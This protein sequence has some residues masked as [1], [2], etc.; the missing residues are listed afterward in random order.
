MKYVK[1]AMLRTGAIIIAIAATL[2]SMVYVAINV[3]ILS[4]ISEAV[5]S[6]EEGYE[7]WMSLVITGCVINTLIGGLEQCGYTLTIHKIFLYLNNI[8]VDKVLNADYALYTKYSTATLIT[9]HADLWKMASLLR[10]ISTMITSVINFAFVFIAIVQI[11]FEL[12][13]V[14]LPLYSICGI[15][16]YFIIKKWVE[17]DNRMHEIGHSIYK[18]IGEIIEGYQDVRTYGS[19]NKHLSSLNKKVYDRYVM[20]SKR[21]LV[22][23]RFNMFANVIDSA[24]TIIIL[25]YG[26]M[27]LRNGA[28][29]SSSLIMAL[30][31][32]G[33]RLIQPLDIFISNIS[34]ISA[35]LSPVKKFNEVMSYEN[36]VP[37]GNIDLVTVNNS[38]K[39]NDVS[40]SY[41]D[42]AE[43]LQ[44]I[45]LSINVGEKI[46]ICGPTGSGKSTLARMLLKFYMPSKGS[47]QID[48]IDI[49]DITV[50]S[51]Q[52]H[53]GMIHQDIWVFDDT[54]ANNIRYGCSDRTVI[55]AELIEACKN[56]AIYDFIASLPDGFETMIGPRGM[57][58][59]G[60]QRQRISLARLFLRNPEI[61]IFDEATSALD[62]ETEK[63]VQE[64]M[65]KFVGKTMI[66]IA[67]RLSTIRGMDKIVVIDNHTVAEEGTHE[68]LLEKGGI[69]SSMNR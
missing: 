27:L 25:F 7:Y 36:S 39:F 21:V 38:I 30:V 67:H 15:V 60:G 69:Y 65:D 42:S 45:N 33:W 9:V 51:L 55:G 47:I 63:L 37:A 59:S 2:V 23:Y 5:S 32:Y 35:N 40:Y 41:G 43:V 54:I 11:R 3:S 24:V 8:F 56:A 13:F 29:E 58:L 34:E 31:M 52:R 4:W 20:S 16:F 50:E 22:S 14:L 49:G 6:Y 64:S 28:V 10:S 57:K 61:V 68:Q 12:L 46:G 48:G 44:N 17:Y 1:E 62:N 26:I 66:V 53:I 18:E 19:K